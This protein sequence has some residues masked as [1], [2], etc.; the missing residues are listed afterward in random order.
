MMTCG[1]IEDSGTETGLET[2][3][4]GGEPILLVTKIQFLK[5][6]YIF[7]VYTFHFSKNSNNKKVYLIS[8]NKLLLVLI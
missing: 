3:S 8:S 1:T 5:N 7:T 6:P 4:G 2:G